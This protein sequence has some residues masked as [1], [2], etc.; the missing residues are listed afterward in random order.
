VPLVLSGRVVPLT[1]KSPI[2]PGESASFP[3]RV[4]LADGTITAVTKSGAAPPPGFT[5]APVVDVGSALILPRFIDLHSHLAYATLPLWVE[6]GRTEPFAHHNIW[7]TRPGYAAEVTYP[8]YAFITASPEELLAY[9]EVRALIGGTTSIQGSP[10]M[11][12]HMIDA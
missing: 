4:N 1:R 9:A 12:H 2:A 8:A 3:G 5:G 7:P 6:D 10:N 11:S